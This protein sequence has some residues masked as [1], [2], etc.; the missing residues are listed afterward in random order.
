MELHEIY[1]LTEKRNKQLYAEAKKI[2]DRYKYQIG[3][4]ETRFILIH[5]EAAK[6]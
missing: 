2:V 1:G 3:D 5:E 6:Y 4:A